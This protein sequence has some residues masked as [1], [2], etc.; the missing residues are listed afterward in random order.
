MAD[1]P[2]PPVLE[3][4]PVHGGEERL[5]LRLDRLREQPAG[6]VAQ[7]RGQ[8]VVDRVGVLKGV[9]PGIGRH[10]VSLPREVLAGLITR[11]DTPPPQTTVTHVWMPPWVQAAFER[12]E[13]VIECGHV[14]GLK[15]RL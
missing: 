6:A 12:L 15:M 1:H 10:G 8:G 14:S 7:H 4:L 11:H 5:G 9:N 3:A 2:R 13:H